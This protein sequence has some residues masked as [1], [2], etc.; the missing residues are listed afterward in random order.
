M[1]EFKINPPSHRLAGQPPKIGIRPTIDGRLG[2]VRESLE[3]Q[4]MAMAQAVAA[5]ADQLPAPS[6]RPAGR[7]R[8]RRRHASDVVAESAACAEKFRREGVGTDHHR[9]P[10]LVLRR[11]DH[12]HGSAMPKAVWG[13]NGTE[14]PGAVYLAAVLAGHTQKGLPAFSIYGR[15]VQ[16]S[17]DHDDSRGRGRKLIQFARAGLAVATMRGKSYLSIG[18]TSMGIA[19]SI[20]DQTLFERYAGDACRGSGHDRG[21]APHRPQHLRPRRVPARAGLVQCQSDQGQ[22]LQP[23]AHAARTGAAGRGL[24]TTR[25]RWR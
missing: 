22:G 10:L 3:V 9:H 6:Q 21:R 19:G 5:T 18:G 2:G 25:S 7:V 11:R 12:G 17:G 15:D 8:H 4:T 16:D 1:T 20:V 13:F 14:R 24:G 23:A